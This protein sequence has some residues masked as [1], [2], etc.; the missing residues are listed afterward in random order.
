MNLYQWLNCFVLIVFSTAS[1]WQPV[2]AQGQ[3]GDE[4][5]PLVNT[6]AETIAR[7]DADEAAA[8]FE[9]PDGFEVTVFAADPDVRQPIAATFDTRGRL[10]VV[11][12]Y[13]YSD[14]AVGFDTAVND[15]VLIFD[16]TDHDGQFDN[17]TV[18]WDQGQ[19]LT[20]I[21][22]G[23]GG[24]W[25]TAA[26]NLIFIPDAD[27]D[28][29]PD[30]PPQIR[31]SGF[32]DDV[33]RHN[34]V[35]GLRWGPDGWLYGRHGILATSFVKVPGSAEMTPINTGIW[36]YHPTAKKFETVAH[37]GTNPW[38][39][40]FDRHGEMFMINTVIGHLFHVVPGS[41]FRRMYG[42]HF[43]PYTWQVIEQT[44]DHFHWDVGNGEHWTQQ[45]KG[46]LSSGTDA[47][48][49][50]H[51]HSGLMI[52]QG[53][54]WPAKYRDELMTTN[55]H[56]RRINVDSLHRE[57]C[58]YVA[59]HEPDIFETTDPWFRGVELLCGPDGTVMVLD[60]SDI[61]EC[62]ENDGIHRTSGRIFNLRYGAA[63]GLPKPEFNDVASLTDQKLV[64][65]QTDDNEWLVRKARRVLQER[66]AAGELEDYDA[67]G[68]LL[69]DMATDVETQTVESR[70]RAL[71]TAYS[72]N[73]YHFALLQ[74]TLADPDEHMR[75]W[76]VRFLNDGF[77]DPSN[78]D[79][80]LQ[81]MLTAASDESGLVRLYV[82]S[83]LPQV[84]P[85]T[86]W[87]IADLLCQ[88]ASD[89][90][91][92]TLP[93][94]I[95]YGIE[96]I[97]TGDPTQAIA[98]ARS[99][100]IQLIR[101]NIVRRLMIEIDDHPQ[102]A[103]EI[104]GWLQ[105]EQDSE[106]AADVLRGTAKAFDGWL[107][108]NA[109]NG[110]P[111]ASE[112]WSALEDSEIGRD[113]QS[114]NLVFGDGRTL[115]QLRQLV[116]DKNASV[117]TRRRAIEVW[118]ATRPP[119][120]FEVLKPLMRDAA[121]ASAV[122]SALVHSDDPEVAKLVLRRF[123]AMDPASQSAAIETLG[124]RTEWAAK[125]VDAMKAGR[126]DP[127]RV[128]AWQANRIYNLGDTDINADLQLV[129]GR[130]RESPAEK[131][132]TITSLTT[133]LDSPDFKGDASQGRALFVKNCSICH[134]L[135]GAGGTTGPDLTG[136]D[137]FNTSY[138]LSN[139][140]DPSR[141]IADSFRASI[142]ATDDGRIITGLVL[143]QTEKIVRVQ[144]PTEIL[145]LPTDSIEGM[146]RTDQ[147][148]MPEGILENLSNEQIADLFSYLMSKQQVP[149]PAE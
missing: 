112:R 145:S 121:L 40:D 92:R 97:V 91:D 25:L 86:R 109:P 148:V 130:L 76:A 12:N 61:G 105:E 11:E 82:A 125:L 18:F 84:A 13:T 24:V 17:R 43:N 68:Q 149:L 21:E 74:R 23:F 102:W 34:I 118:S 37:G 28:D 1:A 27:R 100:E 59:R 127:A 85:E 22:L 50:G 20:G 106:V 128:S 108:A 135:F 115:E 140:V 70:L 107:A 35:N 123:P 93:H 29:V 141:A 147:S 139:I 67:V 137:R 72:C 14:A 32:E 117:E 90:D 30:S 95:W 103:D 77:V 119:D 51:A 89:A 7:I 36:R 131:Q 47:A 126:V 66:A 41:R 144:T 39:F 80:R 122:V 26:P 98:L 88:H 3:S 33:V 58:G 38:G 114:I 146:K 129:W 9:V 44:A 81:L 54:N 132:Q 6:Q 99:S 48:G 110:W 78:E 113:L 69:V 75:A 63:A 143:E 10:W 94:L 83:G 133:K 2:I 53:N 56:G 52:Y 8:S 116:G 124:S 4:K 87:Q 5:P 73:L 31:L 64:E 57:G 65:L 19:K 46:A 104:V 55:F 138:L 16:D 136:A 45:K 79:A 134:T 62:H 15:R 111:E 49:G 96:P 42:T 60:W 120:L 142:I 71:W 101:E